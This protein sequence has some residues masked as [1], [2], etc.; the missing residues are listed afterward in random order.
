MIPRR[1]P[2]M[3]GAGRTPSS[4]TEG[5]GPSVVAVSAFHPLVPLL[6]FDAEGGDGPGFETADAD[7]FFRLFAINVGAVINPM[8]RRF[9]LGDQLALARAGAQFDR[10]LCFE[11]SA[12]SQIRFE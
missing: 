11:R 2:A 1:S 3:R 10:A 4:R 9:D 8:E 12:V 6:G 5:I 7:R